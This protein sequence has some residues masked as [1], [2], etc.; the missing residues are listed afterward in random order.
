MMEW[1]RP[2]LPELWRWLVRSLRRSA[3]GRRLARGLRV[4]KD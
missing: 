1:T 3:R 2:S 4:A